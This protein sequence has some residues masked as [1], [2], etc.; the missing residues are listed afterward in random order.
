MLIRFETGTNLIAS[1]MHIK[2]QNPRDPN[3]KSI[4]TRRRQLELNDWLER[5]SAEVT[6]LRTHGTTYERP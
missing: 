1:S 5:W 6:D 4:S 3:G 2:N